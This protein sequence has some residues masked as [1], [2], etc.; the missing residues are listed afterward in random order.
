MHPPQQLKGH[1]QTLDEL[2][3]QVRPSDLSSFDRLTDG[4]RRDILSAVQNYQATTAS[5]EVEMG[6]AGGGVRDEGVEDEEQRLLL[7]QREAVRYQSLE[8][9]RTVCHFRKTCVD[10]SYWVL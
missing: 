8:E 10:V 7:A 5:M 3:Q 4:L 9:L 2:R 1:L 6:G